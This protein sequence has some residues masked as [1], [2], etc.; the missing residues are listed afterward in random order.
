MPVAAA[1]A[2]LLSLRRVQISPLGVGRRITPPPP[3]G[4]RVVPL[5]VGLLLF[6]VP[7]TVGDHDQPQRR[8]SPY[9]AW[10]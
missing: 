8:P 1:V 10:P 7:L 5:V 9:S 2:A 3:R 6:I 4:W